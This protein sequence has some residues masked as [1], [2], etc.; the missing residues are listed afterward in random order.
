MPKKHTTRLQRVGRIVRTVFVRASIVLATFLILGFSVLAVINHMSVVSLDAAIRAA[1][2]AGMDLEGVGT[3]YRYDLDRYRGSSF[4]QAAFVLAWRPVGDER[5]LDLD[6]KLLFPFKPGRPLPS[7]NG[8][9]ELGE[10]LPAEAATLLS[11]HGQEHRTLRAVLRKALAQEAMTLRPPL[12]TSRVVQN[13][14]YVNAPRWLMEHMVLFAWHDQVSGQPDRGI[15]WVVSLV[16]VAR[17]FG[18]TAL[19]KYLSWRLLYDTS[20][21]STLE[22]LLSRCQAPPDTLGSVQEAFRVESAQLS[23]QTSLAIRGEAAV[24]SNRAKTVPE[25]QAFL[26]DQMEWMGMI[27]E[28][29]SKKLRWEQRLPALARWRYAREIEWCVE[30]FKVAGKSRA[31]QYKWAYEVWAN[32]DRIQGDRRGFS[33]TPLSLW[34]G[35]IGNSVIE[36]AHLRIGEAAA[37]V[38]RFRLSHGRWPDTLSE[39][40]PTFLEAVPSD[41]C[42]GK[43]ILYRKAPYGVV[44]Y[45]AGRNLSTPEY[46]TGTESVEGEEDLETTERRDITFVL[47][48]P[49]LRNRAASP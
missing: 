12:R 38:E 1:D 47:L 6:T 34:A 45:S 17:G 48:N 20:A 35:L 40:V 44:L 10:A 15:E 25:S 23:A 2:E 27:P 26:K 24:L 33:E 31:E 13:D 30:A 46:D 19:R 16:K 37:A 43:P 21:V 41:P 42:T 3:V 36:S 14:P 32:E 7:E 28:Q 4:L 18:E 5:T 9:L 11:R 8:Y 39:V 29:V 22:Y 49:E